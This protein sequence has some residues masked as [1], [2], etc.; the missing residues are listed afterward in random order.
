MARSSP[1]GAGRRRASTTRRR[2]GEIL[3]HRPR[4]DRRAAPVL[5][6]GHRVVHGGI[7]LRAPRCRID[8]GGA[9]ELAELVAAGAAASAAQPGAH[10]GDRRGG[11]AYPAGRLLRHRIPSHASRRSRRPSPCRASSPTRACAATASTAS[12]TNTLS[13]ACASSRA[14]PRAA[15]AHHRPSRQRRQPVR[16]AATA[17][18]SRAPWA[19]PPSTG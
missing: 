14:G 4:A 2:R 7:E 1:S 8:A 10:R 13:P 12:P 16:R 18:A 11:A 15:R 19:S 3:E 6:V 9:G 17:A 5:A